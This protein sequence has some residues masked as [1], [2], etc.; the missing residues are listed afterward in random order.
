MTALGMVA[1]VTTAPGTT[2]RGTTALDTTGRD[3]TARGTVA[4]DT[5]ARG[6]AARGMAARDTA[7]EAEA[8]AGGAAATG[9]TVGEREVIGVRGR[10]QLVQRATIVTLAGT[11]AR[12]LGEKCNVLYCNRRSAYSRRFCWLYE[13]FY[14]ASVFLGFCTAVPTV[15]R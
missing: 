1:R 14:A 15:V 5:V 11:A 7:A 6:T 8:E 2:G 4:R 13:L 10:L 12:D 9:R 3:T